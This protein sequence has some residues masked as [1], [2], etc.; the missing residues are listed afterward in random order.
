MHEPA[1]LL[2]LARRSLETGS[3]LSTFKVKDDIKIT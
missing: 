2:P 1:Q 3:L